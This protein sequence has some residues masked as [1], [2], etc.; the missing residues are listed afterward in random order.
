MIDKKCQL[1]TF[2]SNGTDAK[3]AEFNQCIIEG[4]LKEV[5]YF[6]SMLP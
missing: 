2:E 1:E 4:Y 3:T 6:N 5:E